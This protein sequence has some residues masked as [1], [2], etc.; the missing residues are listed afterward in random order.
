MM[1]VMVMPF[2]NRED[3]QRRLRRFLRHEGGGLAVLYGR[4]RCGKSRLIQEVARPGDL[5]FLAD[6]RDV[7]LQIQALANE[8]GRLLPQFAS[9]R[10]DSWDALLGTLH[11][12]VN[13]P[14]NVLLD[15]FPYLA[16]TSPELP[17][18][19]QKHLDLPARMKI[20]ILLCG[21][22]QRMM[23]GLVLDRTAPLYGRAQEILRLEPLRPGWIASALGLGAVASVESYSVWG[24]VPRY[25]ELA[26]SYSSLA[27]A[28]RDLVLDK[29]GVL[30]D[31]PARLLLD[32]MRTA[33]LAYSI[34]SLIGSGCCRLSEIAGRLGK[35]AGSLTR[36]LSNLIELGYVRKEVPFGEEPRSSKRTFYR[37][38]D[39]FLSFFFR[40]LPANQSLLEMGAV[41]PVEAAIK[42]E[43][44]FH[45]A[46]IWEDLA[47]MSVPFL[48][49]G[50]ARW[51]PAA[52]WW[53]AGLHGKPI[54]FDVVALSADRTS[55]LVG[56]AK[57]TESAAKADNVIREMRARVAE[58]PFVKGR[59]VSLCV[60]LKR[61]PKTH[62]GVDV[63]T[64]DRVLEVLK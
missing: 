17:S 53:G 11:A 62:P 33:G 10:Y 58:A 2:L 40:F 48:K 55:V 26:R 23:Q 46:V 4:R 7:P 57:W 52:R 64:P 21:S 13:K 20:N 63:L 39:P 29:R 31:E 34:L 12:R 51:G 24:G 5:Y 61:A 30:H 59:K 18:L 60:W 15:E 41:G 25:W 42:K 6:Q 56:E 36:P 45:V 44:A 35:P 38:D 37:L 47:R 8:V 32:D 1:F 27:G 49:L 19:I 28:V 16:A 3:E 43:F 9:A 50:G 22:S 54:E 14:L